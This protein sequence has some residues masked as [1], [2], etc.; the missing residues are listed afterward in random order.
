[1]YAQ[2]SGTKKKPA[3]LDKLIK[4][5]WDIIKDLRKMLKDPR[6]STGDKTRVANSIAY[7]AS[8]LSKLL[9]PTEKLKYWS[10][11]CWDEE[12]A[13]P[14]FEVYTNEISRILQER[15]SGKLDAEFF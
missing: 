15:L 2:T 4:L 3:E 1:M 6:L 7:H 14:E 8:V 10:E 11:T 9:I 12:I 13:L 5:V